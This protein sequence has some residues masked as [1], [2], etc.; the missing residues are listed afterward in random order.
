MSRHCV[1]ALTRAACF[2]E[3]LKPRL[4]HRHAGSGARHRVSSIGRPPL[5]RPPF[6]FFRRRVRLF[7]LYVGRAHTFG[8]FHF[9]AGAS[10]ILDADVQADYFLTHAQFMRWL[11]SHAP[12]ANGLRH[13]LHHSRLID[14][15]DVTIAIFR[16]RRVRRR[17]STT[18]AACVKPRHASSRAIDTSGGPIGGTMHRGG[19]FRLHDGL[20]IFAFG[21]YIV[22][23]CLPNFSPHL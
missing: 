13:I 12:T 9:R 3:I 17:G 10:A 11:V 7:R 21:D 22:V 8:Y 18:A 20:D 16:K 1:T 14:M 5:F 4:S 19:S 6:E 15:F 2:S 23:D